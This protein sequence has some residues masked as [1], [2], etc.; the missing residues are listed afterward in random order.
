[1]FGR[2]RSPRNCN[3]VHDDEIWKAHVDRERETTKKWPEI[4]GFMLPEK[5]KIR[6]KGRRGEHNQYITVQPSNEVDMKFIQGLER[7]ADKK[8][9][10]LPPIAKPHPKTTSGLIGWRNTSLERYGRHARGIAKCEVPVS[11][12]FRI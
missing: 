5:I 6:N 9:V 7:G 4:W 1:M 2:R 8:N 10:K 11:I 3:F 12:L